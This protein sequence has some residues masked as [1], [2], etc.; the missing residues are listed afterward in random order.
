VTK[1]VET[2]TLAARSRRH[3]PGH[4]P[5]AHGPPGPGDGRDPADIV[6]EEVPD[7]LIEAYRPVKVTAGRR[8]CAR[9]R[10]AARGARERGGR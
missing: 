1:S 3:A 7:A 2:I 5:D 6:N 4:Q 10:G 8:Q 9:G